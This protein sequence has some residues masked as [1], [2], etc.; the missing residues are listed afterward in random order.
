MT[1]PVVTF[2]LFLR[3]SLNKLNE[4]RKYQKN[5]PSS[6][7][8]SA[9]STPDT[10]RKK[11]RPVPLD[12]QENKRRQ[13][14]FVKNGATPA[15]A[16]PTS[17]SN[18]SN[19]RPTGA[20]PKMHRGVWQAA[21]PYPHYQTT[22]STTSSSSAPSAPR[23]PERKEDAGGEAAPPLLPKRRDLP[24][25][26][27]SSVSNR[28]SLNYADLDFGEPKPSRKSFMQD[29]RNQVLPAFT[30]VPR[31]SPGSDDGRGATKTTTV[32]EQTA[33]TEYASVVSTSQIV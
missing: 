28:E 23:F 14:L 13:P 32:T 19:N 20:T 2:L 25:P 7:S 6:S 30:V 31:H 4:E 9:A 24:A 8:A 18:S 3:E 5:P 1:T 21:P 17:T 12:L 22:T 27:S 33:T 16:T 29:P 15:S 10:P 26:S 11:K